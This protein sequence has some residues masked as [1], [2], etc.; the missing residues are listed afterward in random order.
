MAVA[1]RCDVQFSIAADGFTVQQRAAAGTRCATT[2][3][4][5]TTVTSGIAPD[6]IPDVADQQF[7]FNGTAY[8]AIG[9]PVTIAVDS[10]TINLDRSG[11]VL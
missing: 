1:S 4:F 5:S 8:G 11:V 9:A 7:V 3:G 10:Q 2:G 6:D